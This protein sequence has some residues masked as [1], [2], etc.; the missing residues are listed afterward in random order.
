MVNL[1]FLQLCQVP[2]M[3]G[4]CD[5]CGEFQALT[6][7]G[8]VNRLI[9]AFKIGRDEHVPGRDDVVYAKRALFT[10]V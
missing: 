10:P 4:L 8:K 9:P 2:I 3:R 1:T 7:I 5:V 6:R